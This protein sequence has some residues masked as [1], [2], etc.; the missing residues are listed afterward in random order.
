MEIV[1]R[2][3]DGVDEDDDDYE[4]VEPLPHGEPDNLLAE[5][6]LVAEAAKTS[7][8][9]DDAFSVDI[10]KASILFDGFEKP[11][12]HFFDGLEVLFT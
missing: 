3:A 7:F 6:G 1:S 9:V 10:E 8:V 4:G 2:H 12:L 5:P 11:F